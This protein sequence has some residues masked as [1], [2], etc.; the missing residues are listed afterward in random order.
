MTDELKGVV[1]LVH[2]D[3]VHDPVNRQNQVGVISHADLM[4]DDIFV[5]FEGEQ[6]LY[7]SDALLTLLPAEEIHQHLADMAYETPFRELK[8]LT[9]IDLFLRYGGENKERM[10]MEIARL[11]PD[12]QRFCLDT[13]A[14]Q[15]AKDISKY[16]GRE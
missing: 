4:N 2:P 3:L 10:A 1:V 13:L 7:A 15:I 5:S 12:I 11:N 8:A 9:Q 14:G 6:G 16:Y